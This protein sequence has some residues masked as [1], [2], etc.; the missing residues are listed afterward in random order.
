MKPLLI[1]SPLLEIR[2]N[3]GVTL[4]C[5]PLWAL[6]K[7]G[8][9]VATDSWGRRGCGGVYSS[10]PLARHVKVLGPL[11][12]R[13]GATRHVCR[14]RAQWRGPGGATTERMCEQS[15]GH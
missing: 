1:L 11:T 2:K 3:T 5:H 13:V 14:D 10:R 4:Q 6:E 15:S 8:T 12:V 9:Y 7:A